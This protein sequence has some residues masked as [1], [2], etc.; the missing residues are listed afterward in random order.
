MATKN[1]LEQSSLFRMVVPPDGGWSLMPIENMLRGLRN[2]ADRFSLEIYGMGGVV[3]YL[4]RSSSGTRLQGLLQSYYPQSGAELLDGKERGVHGDWL[5]LAE[6]EDALVL[7]VWLG[8]REFLPIKSY[9][10]RALQESESDPLN[11]VIGHLSGMGRW[12]GGEGRDRLGLRLLLRPAPENW[13][14]AYQSKIQARRDGDDKMAR[15]GSASTSSSRDDPSGGMGGLAIVGLLGLGGLGYL[16]YELWQSGQHLLL[17]GLDLGLLGLGAGGIWAWGKFAGGK[18]RQYLDEELVEDKLKSLGFYSELQ[19]VRTYGGGD[20]DR[21]AAQESLDRF[22]DV[23][24]QFD[25]PA[26]NMWKTGR[27]QAVSG[28]DL[29]HKRGDDGLAAPDEVM[30]W[31]RSGLAKRSLL[32]ARD[33]AT[34]WH[35]PL[36]TQEMASMER[37]QSKVLAP[38]LEGLDGDGPLVGHTETGLSV[39][40]P[41]TALE[42][43]TLFL[44]RTGTGKSTMVKQVTYHKMQQKAK[45]EDKNAIVV[46]DPHADLVRDILKVVPPEIAHKVR[47]VD[48][49][50]DDRVPAIN[51]MDPALFPDRDRCVDTIIQ[52]LKGLSDT[53][54][55]RLQNILDNGLK[56]L[57]EYNAHE[58][59]GRANMLTMLDLP[60]LL[61]DG[62]IVG[63]GRDAKMEQTAFQK[64]VLDRVTDGHVRAWFRQIS[65]WPRET[66]AEAM[67]PVVSRIGGYA[68]N[69]RAKVVLGQRESTVVFSDV[70][71]EGLIVLVS[72]A[73][74][75]IGKEPAALMGGTVVSL[76]D[77]ALRDQERLPSGQ[78][79]KCLLVADEFQTITGTDWEGMLAE[80]RKYGCALM[81]ATQSLAVLDRQEGRKL[82]SGIMSN[83]A[84]LIAYQISAEDAELVSHQMGHERV[85][86]TDLVS[87]HPYH[88]Y[89]RITTREKS[90][91]VFSMKTLPPPE[92]YHGSE[93]S[94]R[95]VLKEMYAYTTDRIEMLRWIN[96]EALQSVT[97]GDEKITLTGQ[98]AISQ[99]NAS[100]DGKKGGKPARPEAPAS[101]PYAAVMQGSAATEAAPKKWLDTVR[102]DQVEESMFDPEVLEMLLKASDRD[103]GVKAVL[104]RRLQGQVR[105]SVRNREQE[106][107]QQ[108]A[109]REQELS[110]QAAD[111][112]AEL[113][114]LRA[115]VVQLQAS[116]GDPAPAEP[117]PEPAAATAGAGNGAATR[118]LSERQV[119]AR[120]PGAGGGGNRRPAGGRGG[121]R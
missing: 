16:N 53:W 71:R 45:G 2:V 99:K 69:S 18:S 76:L 51:L 94:E 117:E 6:D 87:L 14:R 111:Q 5:R 41:D 38:Y 61:E 91:P 58:D 42:K 47:L 35:M 22:V 86:E 32:S 73:S 17:A 75:T 120:R 31:R 11:G 40:M 64:H 27:L 83:T 105:R 66:R 33:V 48:L 95:L 108:A 54:G 90:L 112:E 36:G 100:D 13:G 98:A 106:L 34:L 52:T 110:Q 20:D 89:V 59:T 67:G 4:V 116:G 39:H 56:A 8:K 104:D 60:R 119:V 84:C 109:A 113:A 62:K 21:A 82:K 72:L 1:A 102:K 55:G 103:P 74:G 3:H 44:G 49:G 43:H 46:V 24:R 63:T 26:G 80:A 121:R 107:L 97:G 85:T 88:A 65:T 93:E 19:L 57:Y 79:S 92:L 68:G 28:M 78:R 70:L 118:D 9:D 37:S 101:N 12:S 25:N 81:L 114:A 115:K 29:Y 50:R 96:A 23:L 10:D 77:S 15:A 30:K 7:P